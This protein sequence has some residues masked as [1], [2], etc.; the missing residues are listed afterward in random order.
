MRSLIFATLITLI[1]ISAFATETPKTEEQ[2]VLYSIGAYQ[3]RRLAMFNF[4]PAELEMVQQGFADA[5]SGKQLKVNIDQYGKKVQELAQARNAKQGAKTAPAGK[6]LPEGTPD[7]EQQNVFY[8]IG[9]F[10]ARQ[11]AMFNL[12]PA[13]FEMVRQGFADA[14]TGK[15]LDVDIDQYGKKVQ[16]LAQTRRAL[17]AANEAKAAAAGKDFLAKAAAQKGAVKS[18]SGLVFLSQREGDGATPAATDTVKVH[19]RGTLIN[20][21]EF[22]NSMNQGK[23]PVEFSLNTVIKCWSE[24]L[25]K[26]KAGGRAKLVCPPELAYG[27]KG[28]DSVVPPN[29]TVIFE[30]ELIE[31][32][33]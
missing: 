28:V 14:A 9:A 6:D 16:E 24:G 32:K 2:K 4:I 22:D 10:Q 11:L 12:T 5:A 1:A 18:D 21:E 8:S 25:Q 29:S 15:K 7:T 27:K 31:V 33:K 30:I 17:A 3:T 19:Y 13:E 26:I 20:G 23:K